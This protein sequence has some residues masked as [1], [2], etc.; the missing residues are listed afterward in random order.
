MCKIDKKQS[1]QYKNIDIHTNPEILG[2][3]YT[4][5]ILVAIFI[6][7]G[8]C[9]LHNEKYFWGGVDIIIYTWA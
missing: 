7:K 4:E 8:G 3:F 2:I 5:F 1:W 9:M 6:S